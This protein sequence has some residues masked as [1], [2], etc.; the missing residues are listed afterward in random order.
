[1]AHQVTNLT[2]IHVN[3]GSIPALTQ[4]AKDPALLWLWCR[5][6]AAALIQPL[7]WEL[8]HAIKEKGRAK[9]GEERKIEN[10]E[11]P[12]WCNGVGSELEALGCR[13]YP[14]PVTVG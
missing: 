7:A 13:F 2:R 8:P 14:P 12:L 3:S 4:W 6:P 5:S 11:F 9:G 10:L 1:M